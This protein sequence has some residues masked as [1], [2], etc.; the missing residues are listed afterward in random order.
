L[1][2]GGDGGEDGGER[3]FD[4][5]AVAPELGGTTLITGAG[6]MAIEPR[7]APSRN[8]STVLTALGLAGQ[9]AGALRRW[10]R[11]RVDRD[12][13]GARI[14]VRDMMNPGE[15]TGNGAQCDRSAPA[16]RLIAVMPAVANEVFPARRPA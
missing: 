14:Q 6:A 8:G 9:R 11:C 13:G 16:L 2:G 5:L 15:R 12:E 4:G 3:P 1:S 7:R 10:H